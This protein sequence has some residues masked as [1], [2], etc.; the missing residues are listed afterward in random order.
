[1]ILSKGGDIEVK[2]VVMVRA[3]MNK[4][5]PGNS[6]RNWQEYCDTCT[7]HLLNVCYFFQR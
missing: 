1:M 4:Y 2:D 7:C 6:H 3:G 5:I